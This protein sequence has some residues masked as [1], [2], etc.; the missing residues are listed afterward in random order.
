MIPVL[1]RTSGSSLRKGKCLVIYEDGR[2]LDP[3]ALARRDLESDEIEEKRLQ[4]TK[5]LVPIT[6]LETAS[7]EVLWAKFVRDW[8]CRDGK[9]LVPPAGA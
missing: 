5:V 4:E 9:L 8:R 2:E 7:L 3:E 6:E 1:R